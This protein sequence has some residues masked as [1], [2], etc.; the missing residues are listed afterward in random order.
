M[1]L[2]RHPSR[3]RRW[4]SMPL[5]VVVIATSMLVPIATAAAEPTDMVLEWNINAVNAIGNA[6]TATPPGLGQPPP[7]APIH[8][9]MVHGAIYD[10]VMAI[11]GSHDPYLEGLH[12][13][14][15]ASQAAA[16]AAAAHGVLVGLTPATAPN[17]TTSLDGLLAASLARIPDGTAKDAGIDVGEAAA[18]AMLE[19]RTGDGRFGTYV[20]PSG[21]QPGEWRPV[22]PQNANAFGWIVFVDP[23]TLDSADQYRIGAP[24][25]LSSAAYAAEFN[26]V[27][28]VGGTTSTRTPT[29][30]Q[31]ATFASSNPFAMVNSGLRSIALAKRLSTSQQARLFVMTSMSTADALI[32]CW[33]NKDHW[34]FWRPQTAIQQA[35]H[36]GNPATVADPNWTSLVANPGYPDAPS[37]YN[38]LMS[39]AMNAARAYFGT[40]RMSFSLTS[41][42]ATPV[43]RHYRQF[44]GPIKDAIDGRVYIGLHFRRADEQGAWLGMKVARW[45]TTNYFQPVD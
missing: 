37:G 16:V 45:A 3:A 33:E 7:L 18:A 12:A 15:S 14:S 8:L 9:A 20:F 44:S 29:Q 35:A 36:D 27:K 11:V 21:D 4:L 32:A 31:L 23:F 22:A 43:T 34:S 38:C 1:T 41:V 25:A 6:G 30:A 40:N 10:A 24:F 17:V 2:S 42:G 28:S 26:E 19:E 39:G 5:A 13:P